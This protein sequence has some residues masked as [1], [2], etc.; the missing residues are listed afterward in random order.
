MPFDR[1]TISFRRFIHFAVALCSLTA[2]KSLA[3]Q[4]DEKAE[5]DASGTKSG[6]EALI[7]VSATWAGVKLDNNDFFQAANMRG[8]SSV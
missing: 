5:N 6:L 4:E 8:E 3:Q 2:S 1:P 7:G